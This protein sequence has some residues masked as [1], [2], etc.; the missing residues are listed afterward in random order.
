MAVKIAAEKA[1]DMKNLSIEALLPME[2]VPHLSQK[3]EVLCDCVLHHLSFISLFALVVL[4]FSCDRHLNH[5]I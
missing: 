4:L 2:I 1:R 5:S 3:L